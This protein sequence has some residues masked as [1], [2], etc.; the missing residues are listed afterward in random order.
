[1]TSDDTLIWTYC[2]EWSFSCSWHLGDPVKKISSHP[3]IV[4]HLNTLARANLHHYGHDGDDYDDD[5][6]DDDDDGYDDCDYDDDYDVV[7]ISIPSHR[8]I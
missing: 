8:P 5:D 6:D 3:E 4:A 7:P 1:M 2:S